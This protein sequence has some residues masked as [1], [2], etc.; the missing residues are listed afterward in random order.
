MKC[1]MFLHLEQK[2]KLA[3]ELDGSDLN[4]DTTLIHLANLDG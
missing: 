2:V 3:Q 4:S 1:N